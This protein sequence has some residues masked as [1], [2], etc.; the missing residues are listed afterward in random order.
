MWPHALATLTSGWSP[1]QLPGRRRQIAGT[2]RRIT[3][4]FLVKHEREDPE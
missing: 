3:P 1:G 4:D 2:R